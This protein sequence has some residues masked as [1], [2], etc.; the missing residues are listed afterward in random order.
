MDGS[1]VMYGDG[2]STCR[3]RNTKEE[4][5]EAKNGADINGDGKVVVGCLAKNLVDPFQVVL[6]SA[7]EEGVEALMEEGIVDEW[8]GILMRKAMRES[9]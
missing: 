9:R 5:K 1:S 3:M 7:V 6:N 4:S 8:T 2:G